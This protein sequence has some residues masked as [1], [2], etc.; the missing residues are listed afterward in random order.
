MSAEHAEE[1]GGAGRCMR[2]IR[3]GPLREDSDSMQDVTGHVAATIDECEDQGPRAEEEDGLKDP[4]ET[5]RSLQKEQQ[6]KNAIAV[7][8]WDNCGTCAEA[9]IAQVNFRSGHTHCLYGANTQIAA[10]R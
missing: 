9:G 6:R 10:C 8:V 5:E 1:R 3:A 2:S 7:H 4:R